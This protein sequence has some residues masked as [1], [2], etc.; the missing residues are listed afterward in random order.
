MMYEGIAEVTNRIKVARP[1]RDRNFDFQPKNL[2][3]I[4]FSNK[5]KIS[6]SRF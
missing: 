4:F 3:T 2:A 5:V 1:A 6:V